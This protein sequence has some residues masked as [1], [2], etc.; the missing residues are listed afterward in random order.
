VQR[1]DE[2][3]ALLA[4]LRRLREE[5]F[6]LRD[7]VTKRLT[8]TLFGEIRVSIKPAGNFEACEALLTDILRGANIRPASF[9]GELAHSIRPDDLCELVEADDPA[10]IV[11]IDDAK[12][13]KIERARRILD[14]I[15]ASGRLYE[16]QTI[17]VD[18]VPLIELRTGETHRPSAHVSTG[19]RCTCI[20]PILLLHSDNPLVIDQP[21]DNLDNAFIYDVLLKS[22]AIT[23][24][25]R[26]ILFVTHNPNIPVLGDAER[27]FVLESDGERGVVARAGDVDEVRADIERILEGGREAFMK[28]SARYGHAR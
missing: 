5:R 28:R 27:V 9:I 1:R 7:G 6:T 20:L 19:Q 25:T 13:G 3:K 2:R 4:E 15:R 26:Q 12:G 21:E 17:A 10:P 23:K 14:T 22:I 16:L 18:D 8:A 24:A 11:A